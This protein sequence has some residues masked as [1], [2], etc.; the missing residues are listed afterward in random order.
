METIKKYNNRKLYS[1]ERKEYVN[2]SYIIDLVKTNNNFKVISHSNSSDLTNEVLKEA[3]LK[4]NVP[5]LN[6]KQLIKIS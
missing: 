3:L 1:L 2:L 5:T 6:L 4:V